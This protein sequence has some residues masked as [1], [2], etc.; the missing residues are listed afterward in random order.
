MYHSGIVVVTMEQKEGTK[1]R[2][3]TSKMTEEGKETDGR[4]GEAANFISAE[5]W[6][7]AYAYFGL[8]LPPS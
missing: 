6:P 2:D 1:G 7:N 8:K 4:G 5:P 3:S